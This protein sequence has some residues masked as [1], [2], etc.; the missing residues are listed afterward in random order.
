MV[1][2]LEIKPNKKLL[3]RGNG[4]FKLKEKSKSG[5]RTISLK[6]LKRCH[7]VKK[8]A[9]FHVASQGLNKEKCKE[10]I[11][12]TQYNRTIKD[13]QEYMRLLLLSSE[14]SI[15]ISI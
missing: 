7:L 2:D 6:C 5:D 1:K 10:K 11:I 13:V 12:L 9:E 15:Y 3:N 14:S 8:I 4:I